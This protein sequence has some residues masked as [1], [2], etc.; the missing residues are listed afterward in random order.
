MAVYTAPDGELQ[1]KNLS[2]YEDMD[3]EITISAVSR[4]DLLDAMNR[5][6]PSSDYLDGRKLAG[7][8]FKGMLKTELG[9]PIKHPRLIRLD[10]PDDE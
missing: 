2:T 4:E 1:R 9:L 7:S 5:C 6:Y 10:E 8:V 3:E